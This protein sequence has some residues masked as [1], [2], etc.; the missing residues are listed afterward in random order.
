MRFEGLGI[1]V[2]AL[3][4]YTGARLRRVHRALV[5]VA[6]V[7]AAPLA[8]AN[9]PALPEG[10]A[11]AEGA[12]FRAL[13]QGRMRW[14]GLHLYDAALWVAGREWQWDRPFA[15][16]ITYARDF[17]GYK[18]AE[19]SASEMQRL[20]FS[21]VRKLERWREQLVAVLPD[22]R[23]GERITGVFRPGVGVEFYHQGR[24]RGLVRDVEFARAF[25]SIWLDPRT[26]DPRL[27]ASLLGQQ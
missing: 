2:G 4:R 23:K 17:A 3:T 9:L 20:G 8:W 22:V 18:L 12:E 21:D 6:W 15:L 14:F 24:S 5:V 26:R 25:F 10:I 13:G 1:V 7:T 16:D 11:R 19:A 27:R